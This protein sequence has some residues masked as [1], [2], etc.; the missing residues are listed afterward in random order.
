VFAEALPAG[1]EMQ[2]EFD[3]EQVFGKNLNT[4][5]I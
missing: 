5:S 3:A 2:G 1:R 4:F